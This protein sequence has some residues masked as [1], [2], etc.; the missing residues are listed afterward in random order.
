MKM[1]FRWVFLAL[2]LFVSGQVSIASTAAGY[3]YTVVNAGKISFVVPLEGLDAG[4]IQGFGHVAT[5]GVVFDNAGWNFG[6]GNLT[7]IQF[8]AFPA[9]GPVSCVNLTKTVSQGEELVFSA[10]DPSFVPG[11]SG[12]I[13]IRRTTDLAGQNL[14]AG[15]DGFLCLNPGYRDLSFGVKADASSSVVT[16]TTDDHFTVADD[17]GG[18]IVVSLP[19]VFGRYFPAM[20]SGQEFMVRATSVDVMSFKLYAE[21]TGWA[22]SPWSG[23]LTKDNTLVFPGPTVGHAFGIAFTYVDTSG[24]FFVA[25]PRVPAWAA[26]GKLFPVELMVGGEDQYHGFVARGAADALAVRLE[27]LNNPVTLKIGDA[28]N[29][30][31]YWTPATKCTASGTLP[32]WSGVKAAG[33]AETLPAVALPGTYQAVLTCS[34][35]TTGGHAVYGVSTVT[36]TVADV[37]APQPAL[38]T[39]RTDSYTF[40]AERAV[41]VGTVVGFAWSLHDWTCVLYQGSSPLSTPDNWISLVITQAGTY[42]LSCTDKLKRTGTSTVQVSLAQ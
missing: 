8:C 22:T 2:T 29:L 31:W 36:M 41:P 32:G 1:L 37:P 28:P 14:V 11:A 3:R 42:T 9:T 27:M 35:M 39:S 21:D 30:V 24:G 5:S 17:A 15:P 23:V 26:G 25:D 4:N 34:Q 40:V 10:A 20:L 16:L 33:G 13:C 6:D 18:N 7:T 38:L 12:N 19:A